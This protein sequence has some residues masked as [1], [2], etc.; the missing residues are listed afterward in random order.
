MVLI[1]AYLALSVM[2]AL[3]YALFSQNL[4][5][6]RTSQR[7]INRILA[8]HLAESGIDRAI[9]QLRNN[10]SYTGQGYTM[11]GQGGGYEAQVT[12]P[13]ST[14]S[15]NLRRIVG[16]GHTPNNLSTSYAHE[17]RQVI[18]YVNFP[19]TSSTYA[20]FA[21]TSIQMSGNAQTDSYNSRV[22][23]YESQTPRM[24]GDMGTNTIQAGF[25]TISGNVRIRGDATVGPGGNPTRV[26][27]TSGNVVIEGSQTA[28]SFL[29]VL[30]PVQIPSNLTNLGNLQ[31]SGNTTQTLGG[32]NYWYSSISITG[33][34]RL[35][36]TGSANV[37]VTG[38][39]KIA[40]NGV[41]TS[42]N[43]P[44][45]FSLNISGAREVSFTGNGNFYGAVYAP[46]SGIQITGNGSIFG[47]VV[48]DSIQQSGNAKV[49]YDEA[50]NQSSGG[51][52]NRSQLLAWMET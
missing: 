15:P 14:G 21:D 39:V 23:S 30:G 43:T 11:L 4:T 3:S 1:S 33:N 32:G 9:V 18:A 45:N 7:T 38:D 24:N 22:G 35:N 36:F 13:D 41:G 17:Q 20:I 19:P 8:F 34:A 16:N 25:V 44:A 51:A 49:H 12:S 5:L 47:S 29:K 10:R 50:L 42:Q 48:G 52:G 31:L 28:A 2:G 40:G 37:Y 46:D 27:Q 6:Y 26:I